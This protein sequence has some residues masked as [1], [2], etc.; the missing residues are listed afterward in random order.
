M[1][2][3]SK[4]RFHWK[5]PKAFTRWRDA[6]ERAQRRWWHTPVAFLISSS[7]LLAQWYAARFNPQKHPPPFHDAWVDNI[8]VRELAEG[9]R[10][11]VRKQHIV[12]TLLGPYH[13]RQ[14]T[15]HYHLVNSFSASVINCTHGH[16]DWLLDE[17]SFDGNHPVHTMIFSSGARWEISFQDIEIR[18]EL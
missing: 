16:G 14:I 9:K 17:I 6:N 8:L 2:L 15:I 13:D 18:E 5:E 7:L 11:E 4:K 1:A 10:N 12:I 3:F